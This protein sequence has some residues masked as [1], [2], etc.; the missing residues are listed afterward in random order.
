MA[1]NPG[2]PELVAQQGPI[3]LALLNTTLRFDLNQK[4]LASLGSR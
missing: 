1:I 3:N 2:D 4:A